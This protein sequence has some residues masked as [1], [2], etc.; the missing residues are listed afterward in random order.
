[1]AELKFDMSKINKTIEDAKKRAEQH[2]A[3]R[4]QGDRTP[5]TWIPEGEHHIRPFFDPESEIIR[6]YNRHSCNKKHA[7]CPREQSNSGDFAKKCHL[8]LI[9]DQIG[10]PRSNT[11]LECMFYGKLVKTSV[12]GDDYWKVGECYAMIGNWKL[13]KAFNSWLN[14][15]TDSEIIVQS[16]LTPNIQSHCVK[17]DFSRGSSGSASVGYYPIDVAPIFTEPPAWWKPLREVWVPTEFSQDRY[18]AVL[19]ELLLEYGEELKA[20]NSIEFD[21]YL[22]KLW[23]T[24]KQ[25]K[26][27]REKT[28]GDKKDEK[29]EETPPASG[30][31]V[32]TP[33][34]P[35]PGTQPGTP[36]TA[37]AESPPFDG[38]TPVTS[39]AATAAQTVTQP[40]TPASPVDG[41][42]PE[43]FSNYSTD[44]KKCVLCA[45]NI[46]CMDAA[47]EKKKVA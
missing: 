25:E 20:A 39:G 29:K 17:I 23:F 32:G 12:T 41:G 3:D 44:E 36:S 19:K 10:Y 13:Y 14:M 22:M 38:G 8:H 34:D 31:T 40:S 46:K 16:I 6:I 45:G 5:V 1:M 18:E 9:Q 35:G 47:I 37:Q 30:G 7:G 24:A 28:E 33:T 15:V 21:E 11:K 42:Q 43:C 27:E 26:L 4:P 2:N